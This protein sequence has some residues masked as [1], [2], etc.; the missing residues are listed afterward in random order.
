M[1]RTRI[2]SNYNICYRIHGHLPADIKPQRWSYNLT[3]QLRLWSVAVD[4]T[5]SLT[6]LILLFQII[7]IAYPDTNDNNHYPVYEDHAVA[8]HPLSECKF[9]RHLITHSGDVK[10]KQLLKYCKYIGVPGVMLDITDN[11][12]CQLITSK[13]LLM[14][15]EA[16]NII[17]IALTNQ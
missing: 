14:Q 7:E 8:P 15:K 10:S 11:D 13:L 9:I 5:D 4:H 6:K 16:E 1:I 17:K 3:V 12:Y 2:S